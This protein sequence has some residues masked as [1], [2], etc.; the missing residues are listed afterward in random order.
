MA[1]MP[2]PRRFAALVVAGALALAACAS[3]NPVS[4]SATWVT[5]EGTVT[6]SFEPTEPLLDV[7]PDRLVPTEA[8]VPGAG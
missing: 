8:V 5:S 3:G 2:S 1:R 6:V 7:L 4:R